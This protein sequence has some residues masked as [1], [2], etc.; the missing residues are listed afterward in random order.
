MIIESIG[1]VQVANERAQEWKIH[2]KNG[3]SMI[4]EITVQFPD[5]V[6]SDCT[7]FYNSGILLPYQ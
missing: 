5:V 7:Y 1:S 4:E 6:I 2:F 3:R